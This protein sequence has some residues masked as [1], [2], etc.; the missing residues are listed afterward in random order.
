MGIKIKLSDYVAEFIAK[1]KVSTV[2][3]I[4][5]G[6]SLHLIHSVND[7]PSLNL[8]CTHHE[9]ASAMAADA[10]SR[11]TGN[12]GVA[13]TTSGPGATNL[14]TG[15]C[16]SYYDSVPILIITGQVSTTRMTGD[17]GV[18]Q[19]GFQETPITEITKKITKYSKTL[20][21]P[22]DIF[23]ELEKA[24]SIALDGRPGPVL[25]DIPDNFQREVI[26]FDNLYN[27]PKSR[28]KSFNK[29]YPNT[30]DSIEKIFSLLIK[31]KRPVVIAGWGVHLSKTETKFLEFIKKFSIPVAL[32]WGASDLISSEDDLYVGTF[33]T[34]G[35]RHANFAVQNA[36][37]IISLGSRLDTKSTGSPVNTFAR[38]AKKIMIDIDPNELGKFESFD[39]YFDLLIQDDL[40]VFFED[41]KNFTE[42]SDLSK[43]SFKNDNDWLR[44]ISNWRKLFYENKN[45]E[46]IDDG[47]INPYEFFKTLSNNFYKESLIFIDTGCSIAWA[48]QNFNVKKGIRVFHDFNNTAMGWALPA[49]IGGYFA[50]PSKNL[51]SIVGDGSFMMSLQELATIMHHKIKIKLII[52]NNEGYSMIKQT[53]EQWLNSKY[54]AS[55]YNGGISFPDYQKIAESF[56]LDYFEL[57]ENNVITINKFLSNPNASLMNAKI[58]PKARVNPQVKFGRPNEDMEPLLSRDV[59][60]RNMIVEPLESS[61][62]N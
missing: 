39:L 40:R 27:F 34:H 56:K 10:Y 53:Q 49:T 38:E 17:T 32:T 11:V 57:T 46:I 45:I 60:L 41:F 29:I 28:L 33:G 22:N 43:L 18:R 13:I 14:I 2:F 9:Q 3:A 59:F 36:D 1:K 30:K 23:Y 16:C 25:I 21:S 62:E 24:T 54:I 48:M 15:I 50:D 42:N 4:S 19:I 12:L 35:M 37:L 47:K 52:I 44:T 20:K 26:D 8:V 55:S 6:A 5:G 61:L 7:H 51:I 58:S 31:S